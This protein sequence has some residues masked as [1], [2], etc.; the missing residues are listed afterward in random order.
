MQAVT[1]GADVVVHTDPVARSDE[2]L[3]E[4]AFDAALEGRLKREIPSLER[5]LIHTE[6]VREVERPAKREA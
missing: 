5:V 2:G 1:P 6:P 3:V 4:R